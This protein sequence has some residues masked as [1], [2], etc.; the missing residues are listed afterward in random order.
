MKSLMPK[1]GLRNSSIHSKLA[2]PVIFVSYQIEDS[3]PSSIKEFSMTVKEKLSK[4]AI[5]EAAVELDSTLA[6]NDVLLRGRVSSIAVEKE[7]PSGD[8]VA[9]FR[10]VIARSDELG[11]DTI[12]ISAWSSKLRRSASSLKAEEWVEVSGSIKRRFWRGATGLASRW[13]IDASEITRL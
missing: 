12:D 4:K 13:Q 5:K 2:S 7:L 3:T 11:F 1:I 9:E 8:K 6:L 10:I